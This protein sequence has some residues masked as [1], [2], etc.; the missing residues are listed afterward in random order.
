VETLVDY[1]PMPCRAG[2][3]REAAKAEVEAAP[4]DQVDVEEPT[5]V[6]PSRRTWYDIGQNDLCDYA[7]RR[8]LAG[9]VGGFAAAADLRA[10]G[11]QIHMVPRR[12]GVA[13]SLGADGVVITFDT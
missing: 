2:F 7:A 12:S 5:T 11:M 6:G 8:A 13:L 10:A 9:R 1:L 3:K 4:P